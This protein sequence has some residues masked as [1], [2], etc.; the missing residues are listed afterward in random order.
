LCAIAAEQAVLKRGAC[1][2]GAGQ[3]KSYIIALVLRYWFE[4]DDAKKAV[5]ALADDAQITAVRGVA[6]DVLSEY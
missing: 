6:Q 4:K 2:L 3:G 5:V 1:E